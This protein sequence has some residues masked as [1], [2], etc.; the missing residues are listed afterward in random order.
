MKRK[1]AVIGASTGQ[2]PLCRK[3]KEMNLEV[4]CFAWEQ[5]AVCQE[6][7]DHFVPVSI[8]EMDE[9]LR[10]CRKYGIDGVVSNASEKILPVVSY[11]AEHMGKVCTPYDSILRMQDKA[12]VRKITNGLEDLASVKMK[13]GALSDIMMDFPRPFV[14]KPVRGAAKTGVNYID[15]FTFQVEFPDILKDNLF[16]AEQYVAGN[17]FSVES[18]SYKGRH[19]VVQITQKVSSGPPHFVEL[20]HHQPAY[21]V[22]GAAEVVREVVPKILTA[23]GFTNGAAH[24]EIKINDTGKVSLIEVNPRGGGDNISNVLVSLSTDCDYLRQIINIALDDFQFQDVHNVAFSG[25]YYLSAYTSRL[26][27]YFKGPMKDW[28]Y[29]RYMKDDNLTFAISNYDRNGYL[30]YKSD[31][32]IEL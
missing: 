15:C 16:M 5:G 9:I 30:I 22:Q 23:V 7:V 18:L 14:L 20:E 28:M 17:E 19:Q 32:K 21:L 31:K 8:Y 12:Y 2:L 26:M 6:V 27:P 29:D 10:L 4:Y 11:V 3:A 1:L 25:I 13:T 24:T